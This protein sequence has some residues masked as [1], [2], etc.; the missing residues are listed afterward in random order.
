MND[1]IKILFAM[2]IFGSIGIFVKNINLPSLEIAFLRATIGSIFLF[3]F[4]LLTKQSFSLD[5]IKKNALLLIISGAA[6]GFNWIL[7]FQAYKYTTVSIATISYYFA[8]MFVIIAAPFVLKEKLTSTKV[9][10]LIGA[11]IGIIMINLGDGSGV[12]S[13]NIKGILFG[14]SG[15]VLYAAVVL[16]NKF[17]KD[18]SGF[19]T[20]LIQLAVSAITLLPFIIYRGEISKVKELGTSGLVYVLM[21]GIIHTGIAYMLYFT[22]MK[23]LESHSIAILS[24]IDPISAVIFSTL[25]LGESI[26]AVQIIGGII[27]LLSTFLVERTGKVNTLEI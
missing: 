17:I 27:V 24:Y 22:A 19:E 13:Q 26:T 5:K 23:S 15:A 14:L 11:L 3:C 10:C 21:V 9:L 6:I 20:T 25:L 7:L 8:P 4:S 18:L 2:V 12:A 1:K 16:I